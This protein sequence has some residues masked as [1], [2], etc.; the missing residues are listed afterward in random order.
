M[1]VLADQVK[2]ARL[3]VRVL[4]AEAAFTEIN[5]ARNPGVDHP[6]ERP[7]DGRPA[8]ALIFAADDVDEIVGSEVSLLTE[9]HVDDLLALTGVFATLRL[10]PAEIG[11]GSRHEEGRA[12]YTLKDWPQPQVDVA[13][14]FLIV[15]PPPVTVSTKST[16]APLR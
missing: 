11:K 8:D 12:P 5:L 4:E 10:Q 6:L 2:V 7:I 13:F 1:A 14:G 16:S 9:E 3:P 15:K